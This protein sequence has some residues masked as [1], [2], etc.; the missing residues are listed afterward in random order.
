[1]RTLT[2]LVDS[3]KLQNFAS[4]SRLVNFSLFR[5]TKT[6]RWL[7]TLYIHGPGSGFLQRA[8][9]YHG[10]AQYAGGLAQL[11]L[12]DPAVEQDGPQQAGVVQ[13]DVVVSLL[14]SRKHTQKHIV[15]LF[16]SPSSISFKSV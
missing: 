14:H 12:G 4:T 13:V 10:V 5:G 3:E 11:V 7:A 6:D 2:L 15:N 9:S 8:C 16:F 1:M